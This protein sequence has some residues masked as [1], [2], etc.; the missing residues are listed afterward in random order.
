MSVNYRK[1]LA[2]NFLTKAHLAASLLN[3]SSISSDDI[4]YEIGPGKGI[5]T[6]ELAKRAKKVIAIEKDCN[7]YI[8]LKKKFE[9]NDTIVLYNADFLKFKIRESY[10]KVFAN[11]PFNITSAVMRKIVYAANPPVE[12][13][14]ILQKEAAE[15]FLGVPKTTQFSVLAK[16]WFKLKIIRIFK[17]TDFSPVPHVDVVLLHIEKRVPPLVSAREITLYERFV[18]CG[19]NAWRKNLKMNYKDIFSYNQWKKLSRDLEFPIR[20]KPSELRFRQW[21]GLFGFF[22]K[23]YSK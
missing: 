19:F 21:L 15:K 10:Y 9:L 7:L 6:K 13:Y 20:A 16:P 14:L 5:I 23:N 8:K 3:E 1:S 22:Q 12:A 17:R 2:Q 11:I 4:V 18:K